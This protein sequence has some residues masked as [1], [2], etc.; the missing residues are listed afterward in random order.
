MKLPQ[1]HTKIRSLFSEVSTACV[2]G[3]LQLLL[4]NMLRKYNQEKP[5]DYPV[6]H[7]VP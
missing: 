6:L 7:H 1:G 2:K 5:F 3:P 4:E